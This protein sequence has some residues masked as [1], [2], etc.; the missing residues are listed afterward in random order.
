MPWNES[1]Q[2]G[3]FVSHLAEMLEKDTG[4]RLR[5]LVVEKVVCS[6][7]AYTGVLINLNSDSAN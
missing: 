7:I 3:S 4:V 1:V 5:N 2:L 6:I